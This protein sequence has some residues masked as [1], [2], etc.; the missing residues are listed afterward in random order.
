MGKKKHHCPQCGENKG[1][2]DKNKG[3]VRIDGKMVGLRVFMPEKK[4]ISVWVCS[5]CDYQWYEDK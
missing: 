5:A 1:L 3:K 2:V 4:K